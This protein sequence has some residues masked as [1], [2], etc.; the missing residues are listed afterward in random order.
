MTTAN[1]KVLHRPW[2]AGAL[3]TC[4]GRL[5]GEQVWKH[6]SCEGPTERLVEIQAAMVRGSGIQGLEV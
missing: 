5:W 4:T 3:L 2:K 6:Q 1:C